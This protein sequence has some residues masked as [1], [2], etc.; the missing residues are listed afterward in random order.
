MLCESTAGISKED[1]TKK[2]LDESFVDDILK[3]IHA[4]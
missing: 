2:E 1:I 3:S 4:K